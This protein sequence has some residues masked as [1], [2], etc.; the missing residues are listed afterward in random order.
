MFTVSTQNLNRVQKRFQKMQKRSQNP[1][2]QMDII[3]AKAFK[4]VIENFNKE[5]NEDGTKWKKWKHKGK[6]VRV[7]PTKRGGTKL[8][9]DTGRLRQA[10]RWASS[11]V[12]A[13]VF[14]KVKYAP[15]HD[16]GEGDMKRQ[17]MWIPQ[18]RVTEFSRLLL[19]YIK[20]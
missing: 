2:S 13:K 7:R 11:K 5:K 3:G 4:E 18:K 8:L 9:Q 14:N 16:K 10:N 1:K 6:R 20:G 15:Y 19:N 17:F 12:Q